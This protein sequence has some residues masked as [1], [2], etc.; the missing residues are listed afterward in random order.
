MVQN[1]ERTIKE[2]NGTKMGNTRK[3]LNSCRRGSSQ[4]SLIFE[5]HLGETSSHS[6]GLGLSL[7]KNTNN[8]HRCP[9]LKSRMPENSKEMYY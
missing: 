2:E 6:L 7:P 3:K 4:S 5:E 8:K 1:T 9:L